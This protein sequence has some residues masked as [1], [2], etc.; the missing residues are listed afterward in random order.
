MESEQLALFGDGDPTRPRKAKLGHAQIEYKDSGSI[1]TP[2]SG[3]MDTYDFSINPYSGC[4]FGCTYCYAAFFS[5]DAEKMANWGKWV[6][7]KQ[8]ALALLAKK[9]KGSLNGKTVYM[10]SVT[11]PYQPI[12]RDLELTRGL[13][14]ILLNHHPEV[15]LVIQT[16]SPMVTRDLDLLSRFG[17]VQVNMT[18]TTDDEEVRRVFEPYCPSNTARLKG[19]QEVREAGI[20][21]C[22]TMTPL[23]PVSDPEAFALTMK[24]TGV[25][26]YIIQPFHSSKGKFVAGTR[27]QAMEL[28]ERFN[29]GDEEYQRVLA[30]FKQVIPEIGIGKAGFAPPV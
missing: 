4:S 20:R 22:I 17:A 6:Q 26:H 10:S 13:L 27:E 25:E 24:E 30:I 23:L 7:T 2:T 11:D 19:I 9:K 14:E 28:L 3:F 16:R 18:V 12:D 29:W 1:L 21:S 8:N 5:R 15:R